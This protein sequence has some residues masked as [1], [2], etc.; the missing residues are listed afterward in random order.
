MVN[1]FRVNSLMVRKPI[2][3]LFSILALT[4]LL[5]ANTAVAGTLTASV[6]R[7]QITENDSFR[8]FLRYDEQIGFGQPDLTALKKTFVSL[9]NSAPISFVQ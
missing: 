7:K 3:S 9:I 4:L 6:D 1:S 5:L 8:L 2:N